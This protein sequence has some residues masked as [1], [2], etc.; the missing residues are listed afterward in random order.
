MEIWKD[1]IGFE[2]YFQVSNFGRVRSV[3]RVI[4]HSH[5]GA[6]TIKGRIKKQRVDK[7]GYPI[8]RLN[9]DGERWIPTVHRLVAEAFIPNPE[10]KEQVNHI[11]EV[12]TNN[13]VKNLEW[14]TVQ[15]NNSYGTCSE[16]T[17]EKLKNRPDESKPVMQCDMDGNYITIFP[18]LAEA[19][20]KTGAN[21]VNIRNAAN[22]GFF[23]KGRGKWVNV[24]HALN[25]KWKWAVLQ[26]WS[27]GTTRQ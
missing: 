8:V 13:C 10:N 5:T 3:D 14:C 24:T 27:S 2:G 23:H 7:Y 6:A 21:Y 18:S 25:Y 9:K 17:G 12:K 4:P 16:R 11:D 22:G 1:V 15:Y 19:A 20:R 26:T